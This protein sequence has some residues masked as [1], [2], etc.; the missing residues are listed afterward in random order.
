MFKLDG[1]VGSQREY[2]YTDGRVNNDV[3]IS[4]VAMKTILLVLVMLVLLA[5][6]AFAAGLS[7]CNKVY[8]RGDYAAAL[9]HFMPLAQEGDPKAQTSLGVMYATGQGVPQSFEEALKW[10]RLS[11]EQGDS[12][13]QFNLGVMYKNGEG[14]PQNM[15][16]ANALC[17]LAAASEPDN[18]RF[19]TNCEAV[20]KKIS[21]K[22]RDIAR[23]LAV[24]MSKSGNLLVA[25]DEFLK[26]SRPVNASSP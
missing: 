19:H 17:S 10:Y 2:I 23:E 24:A 18:N 5:S 6:P 20:A 9:K 13:P 25:L 12:V 15:I 11:A 16:A 1:V 3:K 26:R 21:K 22:D 7:E 4:A 14:V 8:Q